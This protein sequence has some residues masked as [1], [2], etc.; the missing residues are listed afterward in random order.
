MTSRSHLV[1]NGQFL[2]MNQKSRLCDLLCSFHC[3]CPNIIFLIACYVLGCMT[4]KH[5]KTVENM[6][7]SVNHLK[8]TQ[9]TNTP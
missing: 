2:L 3:F 6:Q 9:I 7:N 1:I 8:G 4:L 5:I